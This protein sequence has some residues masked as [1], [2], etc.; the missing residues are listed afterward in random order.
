MIRCHCIPF[1]T[2]A[3]FIL[4]SGSWP[5]FP[6]GGPFFAL[7]TDRR[8]ALA[9]LVNFI[10]TPCR[11]SLTANS[12]ALFVPRS[13]V[14]AGLP[15]LI[16]AS[17][18]VLGGGGDG[19]RTAVLDRIANAKDSVGQLRIRFCDLAFWLLERRPRPTILLIG[20]RPRH[21]GFLAS[22]PTSKQNSAWRS[23]SRA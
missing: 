2:A 11:P 15:G 1:M 5:P 23:C 17:A 8:L 21:G 14:G 19:G 3:A 10:L 9:E 16:L 12:S 13:I 6:S 18:G 20:T 22:F 4:T 7:Q